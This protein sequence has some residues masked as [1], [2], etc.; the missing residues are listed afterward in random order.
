M[1]GSAES[2][3]ARALLGSNPVSIAK[4]VLNEDDLREA[5]I[6]QLLRELNEECTNL[7]RKTTKS[8][9]RTIPV[10]ELANFKWNDLVAEL[11]L[12]APLLFKIFHSIA[13]RNDH[14][15][16][17]K[18]GVA[19]YPGICS[20]TAILLKERNREMGGLQSLVSLIMYFCHAEKQ[21]H[22]LSIVC[23]H[24]IKRNGH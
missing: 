16:V 8:P 9:F 15:N 11:Q 21:V 10:D 17:V 23:T 14:R 3:V 7:C 19:H 24:V 5:I 13:A 6:K 2:K 1:L 20:A 18:V 12:K 4:A 22:R